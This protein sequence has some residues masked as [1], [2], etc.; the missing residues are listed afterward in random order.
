MAATCIDV[1]PERVGEAQ[2]V[3]DDVGISVPGLGVPSA[4]ELTPSVFP[5][6]LTA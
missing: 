2:P 1:E 6:N 4:E 3:V 5:T